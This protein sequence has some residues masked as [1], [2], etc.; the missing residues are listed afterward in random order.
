MTAAHVV[1]DRI[2]T[3]GLGI[4]S[5]A[6]WHALS[7]G[8]VARDLELPKS[9]LAQHF[10]SKDAL[11]LAVLEQA[12]QL[13]IRDV[14]DA[15][16]REPEGAT[17]LRSLFWRWLNWSRSPRLPGGCPFV[18]ASA[19]A[20]ALPAPVRARLKEVLDAW[21]AV[22]RE[23]IEGARG[24]T[25]DRTLDAE[26]LIFELHGLYLSHHF[27]HWSMRDATAEA[28]TLKAFDRLMASMAAA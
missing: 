9:G 23:S 18:H 19:E 4:A 21:S 8:D 25:L 3:H 5:R 20:E 24:R 14:M 7:L 6:G 17:R 28:R 10:A 12:A 16:E 2:L 22:L 27:W 11:Q 15:A 13:F 1:R 26:Q